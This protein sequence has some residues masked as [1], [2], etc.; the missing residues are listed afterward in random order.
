MK[1]TVI[2]DSVARVLAQTG[3]KAKTIDILVVNCS[4]FSPTPSLASMVI[5]QFGMRQGGLKAFCCC[6]NRW[7]VLCVCL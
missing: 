7:C 3:T 5:N 2:F 1:Q 6:G 4:L